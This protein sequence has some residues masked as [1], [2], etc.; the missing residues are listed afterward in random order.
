MLRLNVV[1]MCWIL[2]SGLIGRRIELTD[3]STSRNCQ[4]PRARSAKWYVELCCDSMFFWA[5]IR[6]RQTPLIADA[7]KPKGRCVLCDVGI[8]CQVE[9]SRK[10][11][12][13]KY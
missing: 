1:D 9:S 11:P 12:R 6:I 4:D 13:R 2:H 7:A 10:R 5:L 8:G 3:R